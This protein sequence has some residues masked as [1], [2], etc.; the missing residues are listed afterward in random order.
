M[1]ET[2]EERPSVFQ[3]HSKWFL[4]QLDF[5]LK[6]L[7]NPITTESSRL[8]DY[9]IEAVMAARE[10]YFPSKKSATDDV[11][12]AALIVAPTGTGKSGML[13]F[14]PFLLNSHRA[15]ILTPSHIITSQ[16]YSA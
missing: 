12:K 1:A 6:Q 3:Q 10:L 15:L 13:T 8:Y 9:Q 16:I 2:E 14:L 5:Q 4:E 11:H 7:I